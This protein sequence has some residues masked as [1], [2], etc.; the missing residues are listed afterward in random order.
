MK[1]LILQSNEV[2]AAAIAHLVGQEVEV[3]TEEDMSAWAGENEDRNGLLACIDWDTYSY[4]MPIGDSDCYSFKK[5]WVQPLNNHLFVRVGVSV[6]ISPQD[7]DDMDAV[8]SSILN[9]NI[10]HETYAPA[11]MSGEENEWIGDCDID[12]SFDE[13]NIKQAVLE[14]ASTEMLIEELKKREYGL[15]ASKDVANSDYYNNIVK[16]T[17]LELKDSIKKSKNASEVNFYKDRYEV[18]LRDFAMAMGMSEEKL[19][20]MIDIIQSSTIEA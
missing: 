2:T 8:L 4:V 18:Q 19:S 3:M 17:L 5:E 12:F 9:G 14:R 15:Q 6:K 13:I 20:L 16:R 10:T 11:G 1:V 7:I